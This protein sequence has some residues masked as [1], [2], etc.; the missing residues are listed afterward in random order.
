MAVVS[1][2]GLGVEHFLIDRG[3]IA[4]AVAVAA[5]AVAAQV[6]A[7]G[8]LLRAIRQNLRDGGGAA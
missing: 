1:F 2:A 5:L 7:Q 4:A 6:T 3:L 8:A